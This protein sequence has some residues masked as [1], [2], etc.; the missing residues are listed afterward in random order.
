MIVNFDELT[1]NHSNGSVA[2]I[3]QARLMAFNMQVIENQHISS[4][5]DFKVAYIWFD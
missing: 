2:K 5:D 3:Q 4:P 1:V